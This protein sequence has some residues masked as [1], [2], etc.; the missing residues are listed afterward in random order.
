ALVT[1]A[2]YQ[3]Y[4]DYNGVSFPNVI[5]INRPEEEYSI[6]LTVV[7]LVM[8][9]PLHDDQFALQQPPGSKLVD[10]DQPNKSESSNSPSGPA[11]TH[12]NPP[13]K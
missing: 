5:E 4:Q 8:N 6:R 9:E 1:D 2:I 13:K 11:G 3:V 10:L 12:S 7:K